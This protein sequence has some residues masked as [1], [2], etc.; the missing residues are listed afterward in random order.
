MAAKPMKNI[1]LQYTMLQFGIYNFTVV[2]V[3]IETFTEV[4]YNPKQQC[5]YFPGYVA[6]MWNTSRS[7]VRYGEKNKNNINWV[8]IDF[9]IIQS[10]VTNI[11]AVNMALKVHTAG[12]I[13]LANAFVNILQAT[14][15]YNEANI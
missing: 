14:S 5:I 2:V 15:G 3:L 8:A 1:D 7:C 10:Q 9:A 12:Q 13:Q 11:R 6:K 4:W